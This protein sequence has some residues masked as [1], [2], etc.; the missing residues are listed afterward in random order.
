MLR[1]WNSFREPCKSHERIWLYQALI[2]PFNRPGTKSS[3]TKGAKKLTY[4]ENHKDRNYR[5]DLTYK[6]RSRLNSQVICLKFN[7]LKE[8]YNQKLKS[9]KN[10]TSTYETKSTFTTLTLHNK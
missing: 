9:N 7:I 1:R 6:I 4:I 2:L 5:Q 8:S 3:R 10:K